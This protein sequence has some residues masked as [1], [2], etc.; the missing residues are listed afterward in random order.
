MSKS[1]N[2]RRRAWMYRFG[3]EKTGPCCYCGVNLTL[4]TSTTEHK[5]P[6]WITAKSGIDNLYIS[7][8][9]CNQERSKT[10]NKVAAVAKQT[11]KYLRQKRAGLA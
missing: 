4:R 6:K 9:R 5:I 7:C 8:N 10:G 2:I 11:L 3:I 1:Q